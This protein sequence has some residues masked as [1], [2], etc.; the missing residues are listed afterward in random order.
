MSEVNNPPTATEQ[1]KMRLKEL[2][3][4]RDPRSIVPVPPPDEKNIKPVAG[5]P[6]KKKFRQELREAMFSE[7]IGNGSVPRYILFKIFIPV[8]KRVLSDMAN[9][10]INMALG[11]DPKTRTVGATHT[12]N[13]SLYA[14][15]RDGNFGPATDVGVGTRHREAVSDFTW[16]EEDARYIYTSCIDVLAHYPSLS[17]SEVYSIMGMPEKIHTTDKH[18]GWTDPRCIDLVEVDRDLYRVTFT[19]VRQI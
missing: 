8:C 10:A 13:A 17:L 5:K 18:W 16:T 1:A 3:E 19:Q 12:A 4:S 9:T 11:L 7:D 6:V 2:Q 14:G 15:R